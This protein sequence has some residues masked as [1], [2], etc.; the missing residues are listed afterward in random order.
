[1]LRREAETSTLISFIFKERLH[2]DFSPGL[3]E[4]G[5]TENC[6]KEHVA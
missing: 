4:I 6:L 2:L 1:M 5:C 3:E